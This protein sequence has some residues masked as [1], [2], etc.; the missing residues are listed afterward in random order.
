MLTQEQRTQLAT[1][2]HDFIGG[3][4]DVPSMRVLIGTAAV[5]E[6]QARN[7]FGYA[8]KIVEYALA[9]SKPDVFITILQNADAGGAIVELQLLVQ[10][11]AADPAG[12]KAEAGSD[13]LFIR[14][15][16]PFIDRHDLR[17]M[18][19]VMA[20]GGGP[21]AI[22]I[23]APVGFGK[24]TVCEYIE[25]WAKG[26]ALAVVR[27][28]LRR[29]PD[30]GLLEDVVSDLQLALGLDMNTD[31]THVEPERIGEV[32]AHLLADKAVF[33]ASPVWLVANIVEP[34]GVEPG[35]LQFIDALLA[36]V[37]ADRLV[38]DRLR[39]IV[40]SDD[41][42]RTGLT[43]LPDIGDRHVLPDVAEA[44][45][46]QWL[47]AAVPGKPPDLYALAASRVVQA[48]TAQVMAKGL[49]PS[50]RLEWLAKHSVAAHRTLTG[51][52]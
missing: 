47:A 8:R 46:S 29:E 7:A 43:N 23:E 36:C 32:L 3:G 28:D 35:V 27:R 31:S 40:L 50:R 39:V 34:S 9:Q 30:P 48:A 10:Q 49:G 6:I 52:V 14:A 12:W 5:E 18:L 51:R 37:K 44:E 1:A 2:V 17:N 26:R 45:I 11:L 24:Q 13:H 20:D 22:T 38:A 25:E 42:S 4:P 15:N 41:F 16:A 33:A 19:Q 21:S